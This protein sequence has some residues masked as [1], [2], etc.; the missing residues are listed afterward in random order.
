MVYSIFNLPA[1]LSSRDLTLST[2]S[3]ATALWSSGKFAIGSSLQDLKDNTS[4]TKK[5][6]K[7]LAKYRID[8][9]SIEIT[10]RPCVQYWIKGVCFNFKG[11]ERIAKEK[12]GRR[13][14]C[15]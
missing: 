6:K 14:K 4:C 10:A 13:K 8:L 7:L 3:S 15:R 5:R 2:L 12:E 1:S 9:I 11:G